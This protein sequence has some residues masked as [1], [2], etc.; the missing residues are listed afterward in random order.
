LQDEV[1]SSTRVDTG[2][3]K[4]GSGI[5]TKAVFIYLIPTAAAYAIAAGMYPVYRRLKLPFLSAQS[6][7]QIRCHF[8]LLHGIHSRQAALGALVQL[9]W[10]CSTDRLLHI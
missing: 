4:W 5:G 6:V 2:R 7:D 8:L 1:C 10:I 9:H 3:T